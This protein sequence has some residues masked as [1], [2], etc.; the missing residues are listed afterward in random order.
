MRFVCWITKAA[1]T[2]SGYVTLIACPRQKWLCEGASILRLYIQVDQRISVHFM[3][4]VEKERK[5]ILNS[6]NH[7]P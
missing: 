1:N 7:L 4:T 3:I 5:N 6:F 2:H